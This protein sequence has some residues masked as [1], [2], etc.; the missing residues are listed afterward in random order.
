M[1]EQTLQQLVGRYFS[2]PDQRLVLQANDVLIRQ[3]ALNKRL[4]YVLSGELVG[5][6]SEQGKAPV[7]VMSAA[8]GAFLGV[9]SFFSGDWIASST[10]IAETEA[11][12]AWIE[13]HSTEEDYDMLTVQFMPVIINELSRRQHRA[14]TESLEKQQALQQLNVAEQMTTLGELAAGLA[15]EL[16]NA[17]G[18]VNNKTEQLE[19]FIFDLLGERRQQYLPFFRHGFDHGQKLSSREIRAQGRILARQLKVAPELAKELARAAP[20]PEEMKLWLKQP[21][22][23]IRFWQLGRDLHDLRLATRH[24]VGIVKSV[25]QLGRTEILEEEV[26]INVSVMQAL[27]LMQS[28]LRRIKVRFS[29]G[30]LPIF[31]GSQTELMQVW[32]NILKNAC[33]ALETT[34]NPEI[35]IHT[36]SYNN[37]IYIIIA[38]NGPEIDEVTRRKIFQPN[39]TTRKSGLSFGLGLGLAI[40][41]RI[42][43]GYGGSIAVKS[44]SKKTIFRIRLE[45]GSSGQ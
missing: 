7:K 21:E 27:T 18:V 38:N 42:V 23:A 40:V 19:A 44:D 43:S 2:Q 6:Y 29:Q 24:T 8:K 31:K 16:N 34:D 4:F 3:N 32:V 13:Y 25:K 10:V 35:E 36:Q 37:R 17:I 9:H 33:N 12:L 20:A 45:L 28:D 15:H 41:K 1:N 5:L 22:E 26:D 14:M 39:F 30:A 11:E